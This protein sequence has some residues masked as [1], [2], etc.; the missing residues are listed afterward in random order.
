MFKGVIDLPT[1]AFGGVTVLWMG[2][3]EGYLKGGL[4]GG[5]GTY[6]WAVQIHMTT[7]RQGP[8]NMAPQS[9]G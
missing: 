1:I 6:G 8:T 2:E 5:L 4:E 7:C 3:M 9:K